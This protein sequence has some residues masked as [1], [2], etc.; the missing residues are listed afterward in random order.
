MANKPALLMFPSLGWLCVPVRV[1]ALAVTMTGEHRSGRAGGLRIRLDCEERGE[2]VEPEQTQ[3]RG[4]IRCRNRCND[5]A[6]ELRLL[7]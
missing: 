2:V 5:A 1:N 6:Q 4:S 7:R 3:G